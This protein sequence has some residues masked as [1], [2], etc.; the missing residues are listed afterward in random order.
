MEL[1][2]DKPNRLERTYRPLIL[3]IISSPRPDF[4][5]AEA[6][7]K[8]WLEIKQTVFSL[9]SLP[10]VYL[11]WKHRDAFGLR[12][13]PADIDTRL[14]NALQQLEK[15]PGVGS[16]I[17][18]LRAE[19]AELTGD[20][21]QAVIYMDSAI[22]VHPRFELRTERWRFLAKSNRPEL[23]TKAIAELE[24][25]KNNIEYR[26]NWIPFL[27]NLAETYVMALI[28]LSRSLN[29]VNRFANDLPSDEIGIIISRVKKWRR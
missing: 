5:R 9:S 7:A 2:K 22:A 14:D 23:A 25:A 15:D 28:V 6:Y 1:N 27:P 3:C 17:F 16:A 8:K 18:E 26:S 4:G 20:Y 21:D 29:G 19:E 24:L 12:K 11:N 13:A 10:R